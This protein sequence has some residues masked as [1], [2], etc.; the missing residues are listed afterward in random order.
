MKVE[1]RYLGYIKN[2]LKRDKDSF[3]LREGAS[4]SDLMSLLAEKYGEPFKKE[5][6]ETGM[7][8]LKTGFVLT[9]NGTLMGQLNGIKTKLREGDEVSLM[10]LATGG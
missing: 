5:V 4:I 9:V 10:S 6:Y 7:E 1:V 8:D 3:E 2:L